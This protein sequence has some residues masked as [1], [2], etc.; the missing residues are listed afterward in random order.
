MIVEALLVCFVAT[1]LLSGITIASNNPPDKTDS[2]QAKFAFQFASLTDPA[3]PVTA[4]VP[5]APVTNEIRVL[6]YPM[7]TRALIKE[8]KTL[9]LHVVLG[10]E[11]M[12]FTPRTIPFTLRDDGV[13]VASLNYEP[14]AA[15]KYAIYWVE[16]P[17][18]KLAD[19]NGGNYFE[20]PF[21]DVHGQLSETSVRLQTQSY[22]GVLEAHGIE[23]PVN[24]EKAIAILEDYIRVPSRGANLIADLW[25]YKLELHG[26]TPEN[27]SLLIAEIKKVISADIA[28]GFDL[29]SALEFVGAHSWVPDEIAERVVQQLEQKSPRVEAREYLLELRAESEPDGDKHTAL[30]RELIKEFPKGRGARSARMQLFTRAR[31]LADRETLYSEMR[32]T[33]PDDILPIAEMANAYL[34][35]NRKLPQALA[36]LDEADHLLDPNFKTDQA[37]PGYPDQQVNFWRGR[38]AITRA[39]I[40]IRLD[41][42][43]EALA[44]LRGWKN[45]F[46]LGWSFYVYGRALEGTGDKRG[47][48]EAYLQSVV[49]VSR[50][51][52]DANARLEKLWL[53]QKLGTKAELRQRVD[54]VSAQN[55]ADENYRPQL[56][57]HRAPEFELTTLKGEKIS[58]SGLRGKKVILNFWA[59]WCGPCRAEL[60]ELEQFQQDHPKLVVLTA[61]DRTADCED[62]RDLIHEQRLE[63]LRI[64]PTPP[65]LMEKFGAYG[66]PNTFVIDEK[67]F[68]RIGQLGGGPGISHYLM[69]GLDAMR[70]AEPPEAVQ[71]ERQ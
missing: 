61:V 39:D 23:R 51:Q 19:T 58:S 21:C 28:D 67:G 68:V 70:E 55:F 65:G 54:G 22:T 25:K 60:K 57:R 37:S 31:G 62:L 47:A 53:V 50:Y 38:I 49:R 41:K 46:N 7:A 45:D 18:T 30:L 32:A 4:A 43:A 9:V 69:A 3:C 12:P 34:E 59:V 1:L 36:L 42:P 71:S 26:D 13:W 29:L 56:L 44:V 5:H 66:Y 52:E 16:E 6:Y 48:V 11:N 40:L 27:R 35:A 14:F 15:P 20:V 17:R 33:D 8:P 24:Y 10:H 64:A 63:S 2:S